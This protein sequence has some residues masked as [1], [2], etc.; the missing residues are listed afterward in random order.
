MHEGFTADD[1]WMMVEDEFLATAQ[2][3]TQHLHHAAYAEAKRRARARG[4]RTLRN[5][6]RATDGVTEQSR[7]TKLELEAEGLARNREEAA[8]GEGEDGMEWEVDPQLAGLMNRV[9][10]AGRELKGLGKVKS[11][12]RAAKGFLRSPGKARKTTLLRDGD[13]PFSEDE[14]DFS[15]DLDGSAPR[16]PTAAPAKPLRKARQP[17]SAP[18]TN[19]PRHKADKRKSTGIFKRFAAVRDESASSASVSKRK[20]ISSSPEKAKSHVPKHSKLDSSSRSPSITPADDVARPQK[21]EKDR[22]TEEFLA[23][24]AARRAKK[25]QEEQ[26]AAEGKKKKVFDDLPTFMV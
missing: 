19:G 10:R 24:R 21:S 8:D 12:T 9:D 4:E 13:L 18:L 5:L 17:A 7:R 3:Y 26:K 15:D 25:A 11:H 1:A 16:R 20:D 22:E 2:L 14:E 23:R 6:G